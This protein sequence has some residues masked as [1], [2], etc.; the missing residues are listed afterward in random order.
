M[1]NLIDVS[2]FVGDINI[3]NTSKPEIEESLNL[4]IAKHE[5][6]LLKQMLGYEL[7]TSFDEDDTT[8][9]FVDL[10]DGIGEWQ[11]LV[12]NISDTVK[13]SLIAYYVYCYWIK[14][15]QIWNSGIGTVRPKGD[16]AEIMP[17]YMKYMEAW[18]TCSAQMGEFVIYMENN[19]DI[20]PEWSPVD[21]WMLRPVNDFDL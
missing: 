1:P 16:S 13:G 14:D 9:R 8:Q 12:Y 20:Y 7:W 15:K 11:G 2:F 21:L 19:L 10:I 3:P 6:Q 5:K 18:N 4:F 17:I